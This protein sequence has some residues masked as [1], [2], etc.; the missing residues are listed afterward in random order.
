MHKTFKVNQHVI[1]KS[2]TDKILILKFH[3]GDVWMFPGG[4]MENTDS[5]LEDGL[6]REI[7]EETG[8]TNFEIGDMFHVALSQSGETILLTY[9]ATVDGEPTVMLSHEHTDYAWV[10]VETVNNYKLSHESDKA[11]IISYL[12]G[13]RF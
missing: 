1:I 6:K 12:S 3:E 10:G 9:K 5:T 8:I 2:S 11:K 4:R 7:Q 13:E